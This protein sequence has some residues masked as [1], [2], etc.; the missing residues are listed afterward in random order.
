MVDT[1]IRIDHDKEC[2]GCLMGDTRSDA[3]ILTWGNCFLRS[4]SHIH[5]D[6]VVM[7][8]VLKFMGVPFYCQSPASLMSGLG[9]EY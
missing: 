3:D 6:A 2:T 8:G 9:G 7:V 1:L 4:S 5:M